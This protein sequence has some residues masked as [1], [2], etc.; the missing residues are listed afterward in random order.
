MFHVFW[1]KWHSFG[2][3]SCSSRGRQETLDSKIT[4]GN[5]LFVPF[6]HMFHCW[7]F[8]SFAGIW[9]FFLLLFQLISVWSSL[10]SSLTR[11]KCDIQI[12]G[13]VDVCR[14]SYCCW[15]FGTPMLICV[16]VLLFMHV[17]NK[18][19][20]SPED[21]TDT[22]KLSGLIKGVTEFLHEHSRM[23]VEYPP[24]LNFYL[25]LNYKK[26]HASILIVE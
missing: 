23:K 20:L 2:E 3:R 24:C 15:L 8:V 18:E 17:V 14:C 26:S 5:A 13:R 10:K 1:G 4:F 11:Q 12:F 9:F 16:G 25:N 6:A 21:V 19:S 7:Q 22:F